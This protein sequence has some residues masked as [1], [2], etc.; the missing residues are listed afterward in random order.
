M[1]V[2]IDL[3]LLLAAMTA[4][5]SAEIRVFAAASLTEVLQEIAAD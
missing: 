4:G 2:V 5:R 1:R 3:L